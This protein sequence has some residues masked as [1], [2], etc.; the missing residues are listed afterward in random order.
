MNV[1]GVEV[2]LARTMYTF[3]GK[4]EGVLASLKNNTP[5]KHAGRVKLFSVGAGVRRIIAPD[6]F[7]A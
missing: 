6:H 4:G 5:R 7:V 3:A 1:R 2:G